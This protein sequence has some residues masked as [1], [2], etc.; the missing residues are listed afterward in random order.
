MFCIAWES[1][2]RLLRALACKSN[3]LLVAQWSVASVSGAPQRQFFHSPL[4]GVGSVG[5]C[6]LH[7]GRQRALRKRNVRVGAVRAALHVPTAWWS[8]PG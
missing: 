8:L 3:P 7:A 5:S 1:G 4:Y 6:G 2:Q